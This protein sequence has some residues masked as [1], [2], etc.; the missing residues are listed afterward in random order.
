MASK[1]RPR[2]RRPEPTPLPANW[3]ECVKGDRITWEN[4]LVRSELVCLG[5][6]MYQPGGSSGPRHQRDMQL[7]FL[8]S[9]E[10]LA[11]VDGQLRRLAPGQ[12]GLFW[13]GRTEIFEFSKTHQSHHSWCSVAPTLL[14]EY[15]GPL[16]KRAAEVQ[17]YDEVQ[18]RLLAAGMAVGRASSPSTHRV[19]DQ[20]GV[21][22]LVAYA[23]AAEQSDGGV[24]ARA[25]RYLEEHLTD[26]DCRRLTWRWAYRAT[27]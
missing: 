6:V 13:P 15:L 17:A 11:T 8:H 5:E 20:I 2:L 26:A 12:V 21:A 22:L 19:V 25:V 18:T 3:V 4:R 9:G 10:L 23:R 16:L 14:P 1:K 27:R 7:V 24:V